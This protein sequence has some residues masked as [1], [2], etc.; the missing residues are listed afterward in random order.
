MQIIEHSEHSF[1]HVDWR[2]HSAIFSPGQ[3]I[4]EVLPQ[5]GPILYLTG[6]VGRYGQDHVF[7]FSSDDVTMVAFAEKE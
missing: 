2:V 6:D 3:A 7:V 1:Q 4:R 5:C